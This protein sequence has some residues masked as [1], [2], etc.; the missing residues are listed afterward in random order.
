MNWE[1]PY[2][3]YRMPLL[4]RNCVATTQPLAAQAGL[5]M[6]QRGG[7]AVD[8]ALATAI[9]LTVVE[10]VNNGL[11][12][13]AFAILW[14]GEKLVGL[15]ASG[16][17]PAGWTPDRFPGPAMP[18]EGWNAATVPGAISAWVALSERYGKLPFETLFEPAIR[19]ARDG[20]LVAPVIAEIWRRQVD[21]LRDQ[22]GFAEAF[23]PHGRAPAA[24]RAFPPAAPG[25]DAEGHR[26]DERRE[27]LSR[28]ARRG[29]RPRLRRRRRLHDDGRSRRPHMRL[30][31]RRSTSISAATASTR[32]RPTARASLR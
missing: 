6:L 9:A 28:R 25:G 4:A 26:R 5:S 18:H 22:P 21:R 29:H 11:G 30:G 16:R 7:N 17:S 31:R 27:P 23:L 12:S 20:F 13:D 24:G 32:S 10:P 1:F 15:N 19:Y 3:S 14:D 8:A 2:P